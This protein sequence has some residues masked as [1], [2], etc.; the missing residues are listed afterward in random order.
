MLREEA[1]GP[2]GDT[3]D[4]W[5]CFGDSLLELFGSC[6]RLDARRREAG[7]VALT[8]EL[9]ADLNMAIAWQAPGAAAL[10]AELAEDPA[11]PML[12]LL[13][14]SAARELAGREAE[15]GFADAGIL[16]LMALD[17]DEV[18]PPPVP[19]GL[20]FR[21][22]ATSADMARTCELVSQ[23]FELAPGPLARAF[24]DAML[25]R[26]DTTIHLVEQD[27]EIR[28]SVMVT[29][30][31][32]RAGIWSMATPPGLQR[33]GL[34]RGLLVEAMRS[35]RSRGISTFLLFATEAGRPLYDRL[36]FREVEQA[37]VW[38]RGAAPHA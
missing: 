6:E 30:H 2:P 36:G 18:A 8:H 9:V 32:R 7:V 1:T 33:R 4:T 29:R 3:L 13:S 28:S 11:L 16:P 35:E 23:A 15:F 27:G 38:L 34:A 19:S 20:S 37:R 10:I 25:Q 17:S 24:P 12:V 22:A 5:R 14:P 26:T 31:G 21:A